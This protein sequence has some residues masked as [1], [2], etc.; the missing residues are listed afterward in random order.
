[1]PK[2]KIDIGPNGE[3]ITVPSTEPTTIN[4]GTPINE[5]K[6][7]KEIE[8]DY[9]LL[10]EKT[11]QVLHTTEAHVHELK[12]KTEELLTIN[13]E[14]ANE[15]ALAK[16][17]LLDKSSEKLTE[18]TEVSLAS[19]RAHREEVM[20]KIEKVLSYGLDSQQKARA[21]AEIRYILGF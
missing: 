17:A 13:G 19:I 11:E 5:N 12:L 7:N 14:M 21:V 10:Y 2:S 4:Q 18:L 15:L 16:T 20:T 8:I 1:M 9:K 3:I 6:E